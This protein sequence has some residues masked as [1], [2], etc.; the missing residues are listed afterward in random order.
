MKSEGW[1]YLSMNDFVRVLCWVE[2]ANL[3]DQW[4]WSSGLYID[5]GVPAAVM[6][7]TLI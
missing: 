6:C 3:E 2:N 1:V 4:R 5:Y 7:H